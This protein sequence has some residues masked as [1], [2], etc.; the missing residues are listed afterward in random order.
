MSYELFRTDVLSNLQ[1][2]IPTDQLTPAINAVDR[3]AMNYDISKKELSLSIVNGTPEP[4]KMYIA[5]RAT[6]NIKQNTLEQYYYAM[7]KFFLYVNKPLNQITANDIRCF[8][9]DYKQ[10]TGISDRTLETKRIIINGFF[11]WCT[12]EDILLKNPCEKVM[13]IKY[14]AT[15]RE[16]LTQVEMETMRTHCI[17]KREKAVVDLLYSS[18]IRV[19]ELCAL[20]FSDINF[21]TREVRI[22]HGK[23][24]KYR[25]TYINAESIVSLQA[26]LLTRNDNCPYLIV[27]TRGE[28]HGLT[29][30][31]IET[32]IRKIGDRANID[33]KKSRPHNFRHTFATVMIDNGAPVQHVQE[34]LGHAKLETTMIYAKKNQSDIRRTHERCVV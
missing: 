16:P 8:L 25:V 14:Y 17:D 5:S 34:L 31:S 29:K 28:K 9:F 2:A 15:P 4:L 30:K 32:L 33:K 11:D 23:G 24:D 21:F 1:N 26:Y 18:G 27:N 22:R 10:N 19:S 7:R 6:E 13:H 3:A 12:K 20:T